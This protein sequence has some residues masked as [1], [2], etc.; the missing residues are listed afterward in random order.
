MLM[1]RGLQHPGILAGVSGGKSRP[2]HP[3]PE[4]KSSIEKT[5]ADFALPNSIF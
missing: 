2:A 5:V 4:S 1:V 3:Y